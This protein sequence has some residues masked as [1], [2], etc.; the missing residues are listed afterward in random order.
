[1]QKGGIEGSGRGES[2]ILSQTIEWLHELTL[3]RI[4]RKALCKES[5]N[6]KLQIPIYRGSLTEFGAAGWGLLVCCFDSGLIFVNFPLKLNAATLKNFLSLRIIS[7]FSWTAFITLSHQIEGKSQSFW[8]TG[9]SSPQT[10][11]AVD[12]VETSARR[13][14]NEFQW[15]CYDKFK[16][17]NMPFNWVCVLQP[18]RL[19]VSTYSGMMRSF[20]TGHHASISQVLV[21]FTQTPVISPS[22]AWTYR[23]KK[24]NKAH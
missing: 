17:Y 3:K 2:R 4:C 23:I 21:E 22:E 7:S 24:A 11:T 9:C 14:S 12:Y 10:S 1:M 5:I 13:K 18:K 20:S 16:C 19:T 8:W 15:K 6:P